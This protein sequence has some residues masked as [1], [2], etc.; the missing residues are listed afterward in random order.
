MYL[1]IF[2]I[3]V[4]GS[5]KFSDA[6]I[7]S[8]AAKQRPSAAKKARPYFPLYKTG[9]SIGILMYGLWNNPHIITG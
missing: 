2:P 4:G 6:M 1:R 3:Q 5:Q 8:R 9:C 7:D